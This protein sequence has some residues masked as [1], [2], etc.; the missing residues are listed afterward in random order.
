M[1]AAEQLL[2]GS[3]DALL[4]RWDIWLVPMLNVDGNNRVWSADTWWRKNARTESKDV[5]GVDLNRNYPFQWSTCDG[6]STSRS[7]ED[8]HGAT[9]A[10]EPET[11]ALMNLAEQARPAASLSYHSYGEMVLFPYGCQNEYSGENAEFSTIAQEMAA[12]LPSEDGRGNYTPG[13]PWELLYSVD[14]DSMSYL[15]AQHGAIALTFEIGEDFQPPY[16]QRQSGVEHQRPAWQ[17]FLEH[18]DQNLLTV[19]T[20]D[21]KTGASIAATIDFTTLARVDGETPYRT[22]AKGRFY[23]VLAPGLYTVHVV[24]ADGR[25]SDVQVQMNGQPQVLQ[26]PL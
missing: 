7:A 2:A 23:K 3:E 17:H 1:D 22:S 13:T 10:S 18:I 20:V 14:G 11:L 5:Y 26:V 24:A 6:S 15:H 12:L 16:S 21:S 25:T 8:Y 4:Q 19:N 9:A